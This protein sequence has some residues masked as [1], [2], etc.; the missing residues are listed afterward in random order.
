MNL[1]KLQQEAHTHNMRRAEVKDLY[2]QVGAVCMHLAV[3]GQGWAGQCGLAC[4]WVG[5]VAGVEDLYLQ[6]G[7]CMGGRWGAEEKG[8]CG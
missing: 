3:A 5:V 7:G 6:V 8:V 1:E 4:R 2:L